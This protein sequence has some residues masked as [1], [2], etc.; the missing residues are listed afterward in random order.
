MAYYEQLKRE[1]CEG[2][3]SEFDT[4]QRQ[5]HL[6]IQD[7][8]KGLEQ[9][10]KHFNAVSSSNV[11]KRQDI[12]ALRKERTL[13]DHIFKTLEYQILSQE[14]R[15]YD[16]IFQN[17]K[18]NATIKE[19]EQNLG[20]IENLV[21]K[22]KYEDFYKIIDDEKKRY[23]ED[24]DLLKYEVKE[25]RNVYKSN[26][27]TTV[28]NKTSKNTGITEVTFEKLMTKT[29]EEQEVMNMNS[30]IKFYE[31][32][33]TEFRLST[34]DEDFDLIEQ[35]ISEGDNF[36]QRMYQEFVDLENQYE[37]LKLE[38]DT[39]NKEDEKQ[40]RNTISTAA[41]ANKTDKVEQEPIPKLEDLE[42]L[43][44]KLKETF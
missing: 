4:A 32:L 3:N 11:K 13:Y 35:Y 39:I 9:I 19:N 43:I 33:F 16:L 21:S 14:K 8:V 24:L 36:N 27:L 1:I 7:D 29:K 22:N 20:N 23:M 6:Q 15:L 28:F 18:Q 30:Q 42:K 37:D 12:N 41:T 31:D 40:D 10:T 38:Y 25:G 5:V 2:D 17:Q 44:V 34:V 26:P